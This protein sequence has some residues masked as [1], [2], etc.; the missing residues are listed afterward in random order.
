MRITPRPLLVLLPSQPELSSSSKLN[1]ESVVTLRISSISSLSLFLLTNVNE[2]KMNSQSSSVSFPFSVCLSSW[3]LQSVH[4][5]LPFCLARLSLCLSPISASV[6]LS[7]SL[8]LSRRCP[9]RSGQRQ[10]ALTTAISYVSS[11]QLVSPTSPPPLVCSTWT[12][13]FL[14]PFISHSHLMQ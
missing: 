12:A 10:I 3:F 13:S 6:S 11:Y 5:S 14:F 9:L 2:T 8:S 1:L 7:F 4:I